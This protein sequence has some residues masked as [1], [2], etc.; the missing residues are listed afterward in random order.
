MTAKQF[1]KSNAF[2]CIITLLCILLICGVFLT[3]MNGWLKVTDE[4]RFQRAINKIYGKSVTTEAVAVENYN[5]KATIDE[6]YKVKDDGNFLIK[7][8]GKGGFDNGTVTCWIV[9][10]VQGG[11]IN[12]IDK[13]VIDSNKGQSYIGNI[14]DAFLSSFKNYN[15]EYFD[16]YDGMIRT[17][18]TMS[19]NAICN[20]VNAAIDYVNGK[21]LGNVTTAGTKLLNSLAKIYGDKEIKVYG[22]DDKEIT[23]EDETVT[24]LIE[25]PV[26]QDNATVN[27]IYKITFTED[28]NEVTHYVLTSTGTGGYSDGT[29]TCMT[30]VAVGENNKLTVYNVSITDNVSQ[31]YIG[32]INHLD[33]YKGEYNNGFEFTAGDGYVTSGAS[34]SSAAI[35]NAVNGALKYFVN[36]GILAGGENNE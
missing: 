21:W 5:D 4:E 1:F 7:A 11:Q 15:G 2:K 6:A 20:A 23:A 25:S 32:D 13:V 18:A 36:S 8:T 27:D 34:M 29:V 33:K 10:N 31:S 24:S 17:G 9:V 12:G 26:K 28:E 22:A 16:A 30:I 3:V 19:A 35:N 14:S